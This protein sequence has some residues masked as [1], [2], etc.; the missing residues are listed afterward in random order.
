MARTRTLTN[1]IA[2]VRSRA[3]QASAGGNSFIQDSEIT[4][5]LNQAWAEL[6]D[7]LIATS[8]DYYLTA[9]F[10]NTTGGTDSY[11]FSTIG[12][13]DFYKAKGVDVLLGGTQYAT[14]RRFNFQERNDFQVNSGV[15]SGPNTNDIRYA[16]WANS[17]VMRPVPPGTFTVRLW[18]HPVAARMVLGSDTIDGVDG[19]ELFV[20]DFAA[21][22]CAHKDNDGE[23]AAAL[24]DDVEKQR[25][26]ILS[27][28]S[29]RHPG[30][31]PKVAI[32]RGRAWSPGLR[33]RWWPW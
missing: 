17:I 29:T 14:A 4:E 30:Q 18:Y 5:W 8:E 25:A 21:K 20:V 23:L 1:L 7:A 27:R 32:N 13:T 3:D 26:R 6:Y 24:N 28:A 9:V 31:A 12:A 2:D 19:W 11:A 15:W 33:N 16:I 10:F 22:K